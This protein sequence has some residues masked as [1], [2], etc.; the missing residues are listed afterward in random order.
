M[1]KD[2]NV[3]TAN[4]S[5]NFAPDTIDLIKRTVAIGSTDDE[6]NLFL[7]QARRTGLDPLARQ[8]YFIKR[9]SWNAE[10]QRY[11]EK[12]TIQVS[13]DGFR[14]V[15][16]RHGDYAGQAEPEFGHDEK[17]RPFAKVRVFKWHGDTR[18]EA[19]V[20]VAFWNE[21]VQKKKDGTPASMWVK[22][23]RTM[24]AKVAEAIALRKAF[25]QDLSGIYTSEEMA[26]SENMTV[27]KPTQIEADVVPVDQTEEPPAQSDSTPKTPNVPD[28]KYD[29]PN[30]SAE[31][32]DQ[33][34]QATRNKWGDEVASLRQKTLV[35]QIA[36]TKFGWSS[37]EV[38]R[39][40]RER[41][42][43]ANVNELK[44]GDASDFI[45]WM[46]KE[47]RSRQTVTA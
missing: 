8:I 47:P 41:F 26:Q 37:E 39:M 29:D 45:N 38:D 34:A 16:D 24:L 43:I 14:V 33:V 10:E 23:P 42:A 15:A 11:D 27:E 17:G 12:P 20:G 46:A 31:H 32:K 36:A 7:Y 35:Y 3:I 2:K 21:Y 6:L 40:I 44:K 18:Y 5:M 22:M 4:Q 13:I 19:A 25:P 9:K 1:G 28:E 30:T